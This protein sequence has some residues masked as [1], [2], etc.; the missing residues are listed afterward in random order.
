M[1]PVRGGFDNWNVS[2][3]GFVSRLIYAFPIG[4]TLTRVGIVGFNST[5][6]PEFDFDDYNNSQTMSEAVSRIEIRGGET[7]IAQVN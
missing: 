4:S 2:V 6:W 7:N 5:A 3:L 1:D